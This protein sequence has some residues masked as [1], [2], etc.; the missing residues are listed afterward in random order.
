[1]SEGRRTCTLAIEFL[2]NQRKSWSRAQLSKEHMINRVAALVPSGRLSQDSKT[3]RFPIQNVV[4]IED[5]MC[6][7]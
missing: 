1:M 4:E 5:E 2:K 3:W 6:L 7:G